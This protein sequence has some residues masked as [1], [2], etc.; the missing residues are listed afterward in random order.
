M[1]RMRRHPYLL[2]ALVLS[3]AF[4]ARATDLV[5]PE[6]FWHDAKFLA[7][8]AGS[9]GVNSATEP[10]LTQDEQQFLMEVATIIPTNQPL[11]ISRMNDAIQSG[12]A[13]VTPVELPGADSDRKKKKNSAE[14]RE[15]KVT[16]VSRLHYMLGNLHVQQGETDD[17]IKNY[18][19]AIDAFPAYLNAHKNLG[20]VLVRAG[21][22]EDAERPLL[23]AVELGAADGNLYGLLGSCYLNDKNYRSAELAF[24]QAMV[25]APDRKEWRLGAARSLFAQSRYDEA[26]GLF[27]EM[28]EK[29]ASVPEYWLFQANCFIALNQ[30]LKAAYNYEMVRQMGAAKAAT[31]SALGDI[32]LSK[33]LPDVALEAY[34]AA[35]EKDPAGN[36]NKAIRS[37]EILAARHAVDQ[38]SKL[39]AEIRKQANSS[40]ESAQ[41]VRVLRI[42]SKIA[43][44]QGNDARAAGIMKDLLAQ[45]PDDGEITLLLARYYG[46]IGKIAEAEMLFDSAIR[47]P[48][49]EAEAHLRYAQMLASPKLQKFDRAIEHLKRAQEIDKKENVQ[50][51]LEALER[52]AKASQG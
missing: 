42:E 22:L 36:L 25:L 2:F 35:L 44:A 41:S 51:Y 30:P 21:R 3:N 15:V 6:S 27:G 38:S 7:E 45:D 37:A 49:F 40:M 29:D 31:L 10:P 5:V 39:L 20:I 17:A 34:L 11:A 50:R 24:N 9:Y 48:K 52:R 46:R 47:M 23:R 32:Y 26:A 14:P 43:L 18:Q 13:I 33:D 19:L 12:R 4:G 28:I 8:F 1:Q 16:N